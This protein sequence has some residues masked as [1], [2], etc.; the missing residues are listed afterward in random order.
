MCHKTK[1]NQTKPGLLN[2]TDTEVYVVTIPIT[3][4]YISY[5]N[6]SFLN[7]DTINIIHLFESQ[8]LPKLS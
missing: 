7:C 4:Y 2:S 6:C 1:P 5:I 8:L 3:F